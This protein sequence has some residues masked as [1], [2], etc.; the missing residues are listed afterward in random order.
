MF[1]TSNTYKF[2]VSACFAVIGSFKHQIWRM[3]SPF[4]AAGLFGVSEIYS[5]MVESGELRQEKGSFGLVVD[6]AGYA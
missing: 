2:G 3:N 1:L 4:R 6:Y 5:C